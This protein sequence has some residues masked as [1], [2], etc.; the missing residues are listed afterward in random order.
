[1]RLLAHLICLILALYGA[2]HLGTT[3]V[4]S[5]QLEGTQWCFYGE[6]SSIKMYDATVGVPAAMID[7]TKRGVTVYAR[8]E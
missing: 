2:F 7:V 3:K 5:R 6:Y 4:P 8:C 1:M